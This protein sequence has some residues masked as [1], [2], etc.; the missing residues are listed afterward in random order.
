[1]KFLWKF[2]PANHLKARS[3]FLRSLLFAMFPVDAGLRQRHPDLQEWKRD[4]EVEGTSLGK[5]REDIREAVDFHKMDWP[6]GCAAEIINLN[7]TSRPSGYFSA[8][9][10]RIKPSSTEYKYILKDINLKLREGSMTLVLGSPGS[11]KVS[12]T[13]V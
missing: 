10:E 13:K 7:Y 9:K 6:T 1:M 4:F 2:L 8:I 3:F 5:L 11:G 12:K